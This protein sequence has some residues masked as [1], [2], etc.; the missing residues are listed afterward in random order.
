M[1]D[2]RL[3]PS[4][5]TLQCLAPSVDGSDDLVG[6]GRPGEG[7]RVMVGLVEVAVDGGLE[8]DDRAEHTTFQPALGEGG[9][10]GLDRVCT[11]SG[12]VRQIGAIQ[13]G[14]ISGSS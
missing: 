8:V 3:I 2:I 7:L 6:I 10:E 13:E 4:G 14:R 9:K 5:S 11:P 1:N 12:L